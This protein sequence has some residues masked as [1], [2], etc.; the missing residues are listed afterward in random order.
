MLKLSNLFRNLAVKLGCFQASNLLLSRP[1]RGNL[2]MVIN[3][4]SGTSRSYILLLPFDGVSLLLRADLFLTGASKVGLVI[5]RAT[6]I[7]EIR[8]PF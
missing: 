7:I 1:T 6:V 8:R 5:R 2:L 4:C 3:R